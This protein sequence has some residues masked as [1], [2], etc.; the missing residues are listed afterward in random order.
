MRVSYFDDMISSKEAVLVVVS[1]IIVFFVISGIDANSSH[2]IHITISNNA[3]SM[4]AKY[5]MCTLTVS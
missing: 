4:S 1:A 2:I 3:A 5:R